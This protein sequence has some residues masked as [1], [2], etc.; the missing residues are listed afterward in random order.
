[1]DIFQIFGILLA[2]EGGTLA[3]SASSITIATS[4]VLL[5]SVEKLSE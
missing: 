3:M 4:A 2:L 1:L 5:K